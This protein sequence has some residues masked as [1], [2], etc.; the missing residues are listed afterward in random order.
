MVMNL[1]VLRYMGKVTISSI[2]D[3]LQPVMK[4]GL[5]HVM[6]EAF[7]PLVTNL[8]AFKISA[9]EARYSGVGND[10]T[11]NLRTQQ[12]L[13]VTDDLGRGSKFERG[14][15]WASSRQGAVALFN[16][17]TDAAKAWT[18][19]SS[20]ARLM[21]SIARVMTGKSDAKVEQYLASVGMGRREVEAVWEQAS[22]VGAHQRQQGVWLP[23]TEMWEQ[24]SDGLRFYRSA[25]A[26]EVN[27][28]IVT[29]GVE[30]PAWTNATMSGRMV[31][32]FKSFG[33]ASTYRVLLA[34][35][36]Q[37][38]A[39][40]VQGVLGSLALGAL[41]YYIYG[42]ATG[43]KAKETMLNA[44]LDRWADEAIARSG[45]TAI[46]GMGQDLLSRMPVV[47]P[48]TTFSGGRTSRRGGDDFLSALM[49]PSYDFVKT[50]SDVAAGAADPTQSTVHKFRT[51]L[52]WQN[53]ILLQKAFDYMES[54]NPAGLP[55][56]RN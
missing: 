3:I 24:G 41:S 21:D 30:K 55:A 56:R 36:Q 10:A 51:L 42:M 34:G 54:A 40:F 43:G 8:K 28:T 37:R 45:V 35:M 23:N 27:R 15:E 47:S 17:W 11:L 13:D 12:L 53:T 16:Y 26:R 48:Y 39:A 33:M 22:K 14:V 7:I 6:R 46:F 1:N 4:Y 49:G 50:A 20:N 29:P 31:S 18:A 44:G 52:P 19:V 9:R 38:D 2:P 25:L 5:S 32:Q